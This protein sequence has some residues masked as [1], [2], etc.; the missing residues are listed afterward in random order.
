MSDGATTMSKL[1]K[2]M[3]EKQPFGAT[4]DSLSPQ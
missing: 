1:E 4:M 3:N 2:E